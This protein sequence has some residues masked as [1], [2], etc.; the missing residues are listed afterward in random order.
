MEVH[1][2]SLHLGLCL[3]KF[4]DVLTKTICAFFWAHGIGIY[5]ST[6]SWDLLSV[7]RWSRTS[8]LD[9]SH[10]RVWLYSDRSTMSRESRGA[11]G[12]S[13]HASWRYDDSVCHRLMRNHGSMVLYCHIF[14]VG[15]CRCKP[16]DR[17]PVFELW[18]ISWG[19][20]KFFDC[21]RLGVW[22][23]L[24]CGSLCTLCLKTSPPFSTV[25]W[26]PITRF[27]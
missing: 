9:L 3:C 18:E 11:V 17:I 20:G 10:S 24:R 12:S 16:S 27:W 22:P 1:S 13:R 4:D 7:S 26:K 8:A 25:T 2:F 14:S 21:R 6:D 23:K 19:E 15:S 5:S